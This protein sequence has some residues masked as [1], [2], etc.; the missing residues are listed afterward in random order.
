L[1][2]I[3][4][5][6][7]LHLLQLRRYKRVAFSNVAFLKDVQKET[8]SRHRLRNL[9]ILL[10]RIL[11]FS[12]LVMAFAD[13]ILREDGSEAQTARAAVS[14]YVD[15]SPSMMGTG[16]NSSL[17]QE[18][19]QKASS[20]VE[21]F[22]ETDKFHV[23]TSDFEGQDQRFVTQ[24]EALERIAA[25]QVG[26]QAPSL[27]AV[28]RRASDQL[29]RR[30]DA[31]GWSFWVSDLQRTSHQVLDSQQPDTT[32]EW[33]VVPVLPNAVPNVWIDSVWFDAPIAL[34]N[35]PA[36]LHVRIAHDASEGVD[37]LPLTLQMD[38]VTEAIGSFHVVPGMS[39]DTVLRF[40]HGTPG[41]HVLAVSLRDAPVQFDD[42]HFM[43][44]NV[45]EAVE[46]F[47]W[48]D[49][50]D[51]TTPG[52][53]D[54]ALASGAPAVKSTTET[55]LPSP[56]ELSRFDLV[57]ADALTDPAPGSLALLRDFN[58]AGGTV[59]I[60]PDSAGRGVIALAEAMS[61]PLPRGWIRENGQ[62]S[63]VQWKHPLFQGVFRHVPS[64]IDW[65]AYD[66]LLDRPRSLDEDV[67]A[68]AAN[69]LPYWSVLSNE[70][71]RGGDIHWLA[72][73]LETGNLT[74]HGLFVPLI[75]RVAQSARN[76]QSHS[77][78]LGKDL[79]LVIPVS[80]DNDNSRSADIA[81]TIQAVSSEDAEASSNA[82]QRIVPEVRI[83]PEGVKLG[84]GDA[85]SVPGAYLV[86]RDDSTLASFGMNL[87]RVESNLEAWDVQTWEEAV[88][89]E[90]W[91]HV[92]LW[93]RPAEG[94]GAMV[95]QH[96]SGKRL[97]WYFFAATL[98]A[99]A[100]ESI[101]LRRWNKLFS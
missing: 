58:N 75:L 77:L 85:L 50:L 8:Q 99:L 87:D 37:A 97:A 22:E 59:L 4:I 47:H 5:P 57:I 80:S 74:R 48:V 93:L 16:E 38:G 96:I 49:D 32:V 24:L 30:G 76:V 17:L 63:H 92:E 60:V 68:I 28:I 2:A 72:T 94:L 23:F 53:L 86:Q 40:T 78:T 43:G 46:V 18:A 15:N 26:N 25:I 90:G 55:S 41:P 6:I 31:A 35:E 14:V 67:I 70:A 1:W 20:L 100:F 29:G 52:L 66:R 19:K 36:A 64:N 83:T 39:T 44:Y 7:A 9:L 13:P 42:V 91:S 65:P 101:L 82:P 3:A 11:A 33:R 89:G 10:S 27:D 73:P 69:G 21:A 98:M 56:Q 62:V 34:A 88:D 54:R 95:E 81:W 45:E 51:A 79:A 84:W 71:D 12:C 61:L